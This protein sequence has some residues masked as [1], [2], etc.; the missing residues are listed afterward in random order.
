V[1]YPSGSVFASG[2]GGSC[3]ACFGGND[4]VLG[5]ELVDRDDCE[6]NFGETLGLVVDA[7][8]ALFLEKRPILRKTIDKK[9]EERKE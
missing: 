2:G 9:K 5:E 1:R 8:E 4:G 7:F 3:A 6:S